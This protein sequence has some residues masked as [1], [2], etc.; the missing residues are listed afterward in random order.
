MLFIVWFFDIIIHA[1]NT[2]QAK[3]IAS[4]S[5]L[6]IDTTVFIFNAF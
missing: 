4:L 5:F 6:I 2:T 1:Y 3:G